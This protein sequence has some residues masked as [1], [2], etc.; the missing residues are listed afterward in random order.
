MDCHRPLAFAMT[1][2]TNG[3]ELFYFFIKNILLVVHL[4]TKRK[5]LPFVKHK[6]K[7]NKIKTNLYL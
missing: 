3:N 1:N 7:Y 4:F 5:L 2:G 6:N